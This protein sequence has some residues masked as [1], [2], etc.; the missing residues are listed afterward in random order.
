MSDD[1]SEAKSGKGSPLILVL[2]LVG[3]L[4]IGGVATFFL[5][6]MITGGAEQDEV[7]EEKTETQEDAELDIL[8]ISVERFAAPVIDNDQRTLGYIWLDLV[9]EVVGPANQS[10]LSARLPRVQAAMLR[11]LHEAPT[12]MSDRPGALDFN[13]VE[14]RMLAA[15]RKAVEEPGIIHRFHITNYQRAPN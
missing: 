6:P 12:V 14:T 10:L 2:T 1:T 8:Q 3:G 15:A 7:A 4:V 11:A 13:G 5:L 9:F